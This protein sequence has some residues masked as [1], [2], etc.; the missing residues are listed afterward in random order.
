MVMA[1]TLTGLHGLQV[2]DVRAATSIGGQLRSSLD[3][4]TVGL[5]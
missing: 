5:A 2:F 4:A 1:A 3:L